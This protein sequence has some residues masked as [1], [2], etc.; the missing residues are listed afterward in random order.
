MAL[1]PHDVMKPRE[2]RERAEGGERIM[3]VS[4]RHDNSNLNELLE[5]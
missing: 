3:S 4:Y 5:R 2:H 1:N